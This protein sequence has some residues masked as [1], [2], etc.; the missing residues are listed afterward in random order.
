MSGLEEEKVLYDVL[1]LFAEEEKAGIR[2][3]AGK[4]IAEL[5]STHAIHACR[6]L[7][8]AE[9]NQFLQD[10]S[11]CANPYQSPSGHATFVIIEERDL[12]KEFR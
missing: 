12:A 1:D 3:I 8:L 7:A 6:K 9:M 4:K 10:L 2:R 11:A 5:A